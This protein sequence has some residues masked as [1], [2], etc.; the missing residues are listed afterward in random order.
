MFLLIDHLIHPSLS[1]WL[2]FNLINFYLC[3]TKHSRNLLKYRLGL[4]KEYN[5]YVIHIIEPPSPERA[6]STL[7]IF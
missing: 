7:T 2:A 6:Q 1:F 3:Q 5:K 4:F